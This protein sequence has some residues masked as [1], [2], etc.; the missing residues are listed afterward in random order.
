MMRKK[1]RTLR[2][3]I[4]SPQIAQNPLKNWN[5]QN[6]SGKLEFSQFFRKNRDD[7]A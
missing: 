3:I 4:F 5:P 6:K 1:Y 2:R 7:S